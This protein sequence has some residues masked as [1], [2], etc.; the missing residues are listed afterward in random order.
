[1][2][3]NIFSEASI[4]Q[5]LELF[6]FS[7]ICMKDPQIF[8][9]NSYGFQIFFWSN[10]TSSFK[11]SLSFQHVLGPFAFETGWRG[12]LNSDVRKEQLINI[13]VRVW[14]CL[15]QWRCDGPGG[16]GRVLFYP[17]TFKWENRL[18]EKP[19]I[20]CIWSRFT[21][22]LDASWNTTKTDLKSLSFIWL[23]LKKKMLIPHWRDYTCI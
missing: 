23:A 19:I 4:H 14:L 18:W 21:T 10:I 7:H 20:I 9:V 6:D 8:E 13:H 17:N 5:S 3:Q 15:R 12:E 2:S 22:E 16:E 1:M 11:C